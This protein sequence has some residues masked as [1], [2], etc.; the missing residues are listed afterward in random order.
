MPN[1][2]V[3]PKRTKNK[4]I[5]PLTEAPVQSQGAKVAKRLGIKRLGI[6]ASESRPKTLGGLGVLA[7]LL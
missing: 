1:S 5:S 3:R 7:V 2:N 4:S 6:V